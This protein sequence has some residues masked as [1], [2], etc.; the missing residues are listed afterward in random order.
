[1]AVCVVTFWEIS[2]KYGLG[3]LKMSGVTPEE[4]TDFTGQMNPIKLLGMTFSFS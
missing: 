3:K 4:L 2:L 1:V